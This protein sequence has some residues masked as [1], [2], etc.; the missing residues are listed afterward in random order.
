MLIGWVML[1]M[2]KFKILTKHISKLTCIRQPHAFSGHFLLC[3]LTGCLTQVLLY[4]KKE[5]G[6]EG[7]TEDGLVF[8][9]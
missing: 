9:W 3:A 7:I 1:I 6:V 4:I 5:K 8:A 2:L